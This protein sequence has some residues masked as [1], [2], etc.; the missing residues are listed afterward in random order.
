LDFL[1]LYFDHKEPYFS[2]TRAIPPSS[3]GQ[4][5]NN[6]RGHP[7]HAFLEPEP[8]FS[9]KGRQQSSQEIP[10]CGRSNKKQ[11]LANT[12]AID[13]YHNRELN[14]SNLKK[15]EDARRNNLSAMEESC[16]NLFDISIPDRLAALSTGALQK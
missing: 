16:L 7:N 4:T 3:P 15:C 14:H 5:T 10:S 9:G 12:P 6:Y 8:Q 2:E 11:E 13:K 1:W